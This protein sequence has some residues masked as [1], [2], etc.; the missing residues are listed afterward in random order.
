MSNE[1]KNYQDG[2]RG[3]PFAS[4]AGQL[5]YEMY[6]KRQQRESG[7]H[8]SGRSSNKT[9]SQV[10]PE[11]EEAFSGFLN[12]IGVGIGAVYAKSV[13]LERWISKVVNFVHPG[14]AVLAVLVGSIVKFSYDLYL[15]NAVTDALYGASVQYGI[16]LAVMGIFLWISYVLT[17][18][19]IGL[20]LV[21]LPVLILGLVMGAMTGEL[22]LDF[23]W[24]QSWL[25]K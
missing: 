22:S 1:F 21:L 15:G 19:L 4:G 3:N 11:M 14:A 13:F 18:F 9:R 25:G 12:D 7:R 23:S 5:G 6:K 20:A 16:W 2:D 8:A 10:S 17:R 24:V